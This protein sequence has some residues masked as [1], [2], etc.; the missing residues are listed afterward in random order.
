MLTQ[1]ELAEKTGLKQSAIA[2]IEK[3]QAAL[4]IKTL[5]KI[6]KAYGAKVII[7]FQLPERLT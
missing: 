2:R 3:G 1:R 6:A 4:N 5:E 7:T